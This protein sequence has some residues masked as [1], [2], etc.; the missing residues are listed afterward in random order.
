MITLN[1]LKEEAALEKRLRADISSPG[2]T[3]WIQFVQT[4]GRRS[5]FWKREAMWHG[6]F[7]SANWKTYFW[8]SKL[9]NASK[10]ESFRSLRISTDSTEVIYLF[11]ESFLDHACSERRVALQGPCQYS[12]CL[13]LY[14][15]TDRKIIRNSRL[16][17]EKHNDITVFRTGTTFKLENMFKRCDLG[18]IMFSAQ[19]MYEN[20][21]WSVPNR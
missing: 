8:V 18:V 14:V 17:S 15:Y 2:R 16:I 1:E 20:T 21:K 7:L 9:C 4:S 6:L 19:A 13:G 11:L 3:L 12:C 5:S 10:S